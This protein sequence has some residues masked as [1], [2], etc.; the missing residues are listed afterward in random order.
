MA[1]VSNGN[2]S[3]SASTNGAEIENGHIAPE[4]NVVYVLD[5]SFFASEQK[6]DNSFVWN[7][8]GG[9]AAHAD[10]TSVDN[11]TC[12]ND[13]IIAQP[14]T[15]QYGITQLRHDPETRKPIE[16]G[17]PASS[18]NS[19]GISSPTPGYSKGKTKDHRGEIKTLN[20][21]LDSNER[22]MQE[23]SGILVSLNEKFT[24]FVE[25]APRPNITTESIQSDDD[26]DEG[27]SSDDNY[28]V[29]DGVLPVKTTDVNNESK[30]KK[31]LDFSAKVDGKKEC[32]PPVNETLATAVQNSINVNFDQEKG[33]KLA[34]AIEYPENCS[35]LAPPKVNEEI[36]HDSF[37]SKPLRIQD[38]GLQNIQLFIGKAMVPMINMMDSMLESDS[39][40]ST[41]WFNQAFEAVE[42]LTFAHRDVTNNRRKLLKPALKPEFGK[43]CAPKTPVTNHLFGDNLSERV[44][45]ITDMKKLGKDIAKFEKKLGKKRTYGVKDMPRNTYSS[46]NPN[47]NQSH[48]QPPVKR[49]YT[50]K[51]YNVAKDFLSRQGLSHRDKQKTQGQGQY[52]KNKK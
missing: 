25:N 46:S 28:S 19:V 44:K 40:E 14:A 51:H 52:Q 24:N 6:T 42:L 21:R 10:Q 22:Q 5:P 23:I 41:K 50:S 49:Q 45:S 13:P 3:P 11:I 33:K 4:Q 39:Q 7:K 9:E 8:N 27:N 12:S 47:Y 2:I 43:F 20:A 37:I 32:G 1:G 48:G 15:L 16:N 31:L 18:I 38:C 30:L 29:Q 17:N 35:L 36:W 34:D 26:D